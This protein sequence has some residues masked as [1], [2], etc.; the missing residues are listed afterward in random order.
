MS[1]KGGRRAGRYRTAS[2]GEAY[3]GLKTSSSRTFRILS[4]V[5]FV[6][7]YSLASFRDLELVHCGGRPI[8]AEP[9]GESFAGG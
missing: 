6:Y 3:R 9:D 8:L 4:T 7:M 5:K 2:V 1:K